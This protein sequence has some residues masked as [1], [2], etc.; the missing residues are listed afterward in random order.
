[1]KNSS[2]FFHLRW[3]F[4]FRVTLS[5][6]ALVFG[7][8]LVA[9]TTVPGAASPSTSETMT[10]D[11]ALKSKIDDKSFVEIAAT[12]GLA[13]IEMA[14]LAKG[15]SRNDKIL[16]FADMML[17][18]HEAM[19]AKLRKVA[20]ANQLSI[21]TALTDDQQKML[22]EL[23]TK[24]GEQFDRMYVDVM[25][26]EHDAT[27]GLFDNAA[28]EVKLN[29]QLRT[30]ATEALGLLREHQRRAHALVNS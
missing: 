25:R 12:G 22:T 23:K 20:T 14:K 19:G 9:Q 26:K 2:A 13:E 3:L 4:R 28:G 15:K 6:V 24:S 27:V 30:F 16:E 29:P 7:S 11:G 21:P 5:I 10:K 18:D 17:R 8:Q 1:M